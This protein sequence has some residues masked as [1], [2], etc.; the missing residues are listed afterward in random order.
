[1]R[2]H[3]ASRL[4]DDYSLPATISERGLRTNPD[5]SCTYGERNSAP[6]EASWWLSRLDAGYVREAGPH[7]L[8]MTST[9]ALSAMDYERI[10]RTTLGLALDTSREEGERRAACNT[11]C[12]VSGELFR[13]LDDHARDGQRLAWGRGQG[14]SGAQQIGA[15]M[16]LTA[17][18]QVRLT[19]VIRHS[20]SCA[21]QAWALEARRKRE[22]LGGPRR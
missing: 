16:T 2:G 11:F 20:L 22:A 21:V 17:W 5:G 13:E 1:M 6:A 3:R 8:R 10:A 18:G 9:N 12:A 7:I 14:T 19:P 4:T 15:S